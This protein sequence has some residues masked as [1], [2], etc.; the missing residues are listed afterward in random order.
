M[1]TD[2]ARWGRS[3]GGL[4][5][6]AGD[7][8]GPQ[9]IEQALQRL[10]LQAGSIPFVGLQKKR[11]SPELCHHCAHGDELSYSPRPK[12]PA[13]EE[14][15]SQTQVPSTAKGDTRSF[16]GL[17]PPTVTATV[18]SSKERADAELLG[19][20]HLGWPA[21]WAEGH[22][23]P[24]K[25]LWVPGPLQGASLNHTGCSSLKLYT[26][27]ALCMCVQSYQP[28]CYAMDCPLST[29]LLCPCTEPNAFCEISFKVFISL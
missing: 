6:I 20:A 27:Q 25:T 17:H 15:Q 7:G 5:N 11:G 28:L 21:V 16:P 12:C 1:K 4:I 18:G 23:R 22:L 8:G 13:T 19:L 3:P 14:P 29:W 10:S 24:R 26:F 2:I 9:R